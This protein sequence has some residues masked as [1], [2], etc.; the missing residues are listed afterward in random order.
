[1][2]GI[3]EACFYTTHNHGS[4]DKA[5]YGIANDPYNKV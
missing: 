5:Q 2:K 1:M 3:V 4:H